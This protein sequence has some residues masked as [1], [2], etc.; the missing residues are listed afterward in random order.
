MQ[1]PN[2]SD[3]DNTESEPKKVKLDPFIRADLNA[4]YEWSPDANKKTL[5]C[6]T[7]RKFEKQYSSLRGWYDF[8]R[9]LVSEFS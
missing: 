1:E 2:E 5:V 7:C 8:E 3:L 4:F 6:K 9:H